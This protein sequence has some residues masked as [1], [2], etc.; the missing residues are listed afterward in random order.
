MTEIEHNCRAEPSPVA[1]WDDPGIGG[2]PGIG[3]TGFIMF[4][5]DASFLVDPDG[6][7]LLI[8]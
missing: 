2:N 4:P 5:D 6:F 1:S 8:P 7:R 3:G